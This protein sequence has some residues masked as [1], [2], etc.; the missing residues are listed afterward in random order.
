MKPGDSKRAPVILLETAR[1]PR[2][3]A[4]VFGA[5][6][7]V[8]ALVIGALIFTSTKVF[9]PDIKTEVFQLP[10]V[11]EDKLPEVHYSAGNPKPAAARSSSAHKAA[12]ARRTA[13]PLAP[14][15]PPPMLLG[16]L[17]PPV[18]PPKPSSVT[19]DFSRV[20]PAPPPVEPARPAAPPIPAAP[21]TANAAG[22]ADANVSG[23]G[24]GAAAG[25]GASRS[26][27]DL[28]AGDPVFTPFDIAPELINRGEIRELL[29][30]RA[31]RWQRRGMEGLVILWILIDTKG[32]AHKAVIHTSSGRGEFD[33]AAMGSVRFMRF[34]AARS[35]GEKVPVWVQLP[36]RF[37]A[38]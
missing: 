17:V 7:L 9:Q 32:K 12:P 11:I 30:Q 1:D 6:A 19:P 38:E 27:E 31:G 37:V 24:T 4:T 5:S 33:E 22:S 28:E 18:A 16:N 2:E 14:P 25:S 3:A 29:W 13:A 20:A 34:Q 26:I 23:S 15:A 10:F 35:K 36:V 8:H 21:P